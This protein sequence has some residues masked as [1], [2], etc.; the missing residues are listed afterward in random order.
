MFVGPQSGGFIEHEA[1]DGLY[2]STRT[3][4]SHF[5]HGKLEASGVK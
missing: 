4:P 2:R 5:T 1:W 3:Q